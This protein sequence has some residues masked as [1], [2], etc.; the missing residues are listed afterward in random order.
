[1]NDAVSAAILA[2]QNAAGQFQA[3]ATV[4]AAVSAGVP[5]AMP[6]ARPRSLAD[7]LASAGAAVDVWL[8]VNE[9]GLYIGN[10]KK[11]LFET[12][13]VMI[14]LSEVKFGYGVRYSIGSQVNYGKSYDGVR[15]VKSG[16]PWA[17]IVA[18]AQRIDPKCRGSY[19]L[20]EI[21]M[22]LVAD[23]VKKDK[24]V[25]AEAGKRLGLTT[26]VTNFPVFMTWV[27]EALPSFGEHS[28]IPVVLSGTTK[29]GPTGDYGLVAFATKQ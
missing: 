9:Y 10:D 12:I 18:E 17:E 25:A 28:E 14:K 1:M 15:E 23:L 2:A 24:T 7:A 20:A 21:P 22:T 26:S 4:P 19:D 5:A 3:P 11:N 13:D 16:R 6:A 27:A 29:K 8:G